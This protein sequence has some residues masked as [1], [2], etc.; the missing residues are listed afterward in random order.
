[1]YTRCY[2]QTNSYLLHSLD[3]AVI[4]VGAF[5]IAAQSLE[6]GIFGDSQCQPILNTELLQLAYHTVGDAWVALGQEAVHNILEDVK[7]VLDREI[8][9]VGVQQ[10]A[11]W[12]SQCGIVHEEHAGRFLG[13]TLNLQLTSL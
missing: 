3:Y 12:W 2:D 1:M 11:V 8:Y 10:Y 6:S 4:G 5:M 7:F 13:P 9:E